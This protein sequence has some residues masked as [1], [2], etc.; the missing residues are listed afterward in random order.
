MS[1]PVRETPVNGRG[2]D[3]SV[4]GGGYGVVLAAIGRLG[5]HITREDNRVKAQSGGERGDQSEGGYD[6]FAVSQHQAAMDDD[7]EQLLVGPHGNL[8]HRRAG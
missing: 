5:V 2:A 3:K 4:P 6:I 7:P 8:P 1:S